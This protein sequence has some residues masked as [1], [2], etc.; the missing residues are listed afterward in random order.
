MNAATDAVLARANE[1]GVTHREAAYEAVG[2]FDFNCDSAVERTGTTF[3][4]MS[5]SRLLI[6]CMLGLFLVGTL[7]VARFFPVPQ[8]TPAPPG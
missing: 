2:R 8:A 5:R 1:K 6:V 4:A 7:I 3:D